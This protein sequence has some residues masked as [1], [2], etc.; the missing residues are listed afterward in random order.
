MNN[1][2]I[3]QSGS[4]VQEL[5]QIQLKLFEKYFPEDGLGKRPFSMTVNKKSVPEV[6]AAISNLENLPLFFEHLAK[7][8]MRSATQADWHFRGTETDNYTSVPMSLELDQSSSSLVW[9][10]ETQ[11]GFDYSVGFFLEP[12]SAG[13]GTVVR[14]LVAYDNLVGEIA[15][16]LEF[17]F[18][19]DAM[20]NSKKNLYRLKA[21]LETGHVPTTEGQ[22]SGREEDMPRTTH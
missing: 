22:P 2:N 18:G 16:K 19:K 20:I 3:S 11:A 21:F 12:A 14:M 7:I 4:S 6:Y 9:K 17:L 13:R 1:S 8:E 10:A 5:R 15:G